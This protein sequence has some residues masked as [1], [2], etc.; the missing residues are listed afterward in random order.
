MKITTKAI[1]SWDNES[2]TYKET[3]CD[4]YL[5]D[6]KI[7]YCQEEN[8][9]GARDAIQDIQTALNSAILKLGLEGYG[10]DEIV[11]QL[12]EHDKRYGL[13]V[14]HL[15]Y[16][17]ES[18]TEEDWNSARD[19]AATANRHLL[20]IA[21]EEEAEEEAEDEAGRLLKRAE[22]V[23]VYLDDMYGITPDAASEVQVGEAESYKLEEEERERL[24]E[25]QAEAKKRDDILEA[26]GIVENSLADE[27][28]DIHIEISNIDDSWTVTGTEDERLFAVID[29]L[30][31]A[32]NYFREEDYERADGLIQNAKIRLEELL[33]LPPEE[34]QGILP[35][36][37]K[38]AIGASERSIHAMKDTTL[39]TDVLWNAI[40]ASENQKDEYKRAR[41]LDAVEIWRYEK[42][43]LNYE[44]DFKDV[45]F[46]V[47]LVGDLE[48]PIILSEPD[49]TKKLQPPPKNIQFTRNKRGETPPFINLSW[50][51]PADNRSAEHNNLKNFVINPCDEIEEIINRI[52]RNELEDIMPAE[53]LFPKSLPEWFSKVSNWADFAKLEQRNQTR[54][55]AQAVYDEDSSLSNSTE[56]FQKLYRDNSKL[57]QILQSIEPKRR[58]MITD[59]FE[60]FLNFLYPPFNKLLEK[61]KKTKFYTDMQKYWGEQYKNV[62]DRVIILPSNFWMKKSVEDTAANFKSKWKHF[63]EWL[64]DYIIINEYDSSTGATLIEWYVSQFENLRS[65]IF[66]RHTALNPRL[67]KVVPKPIESYEQKRT[68]DNNDFPGIKYAVAYTAYK[69][70][71][72]TTEWFARDDYTVYEDKTDIIGYRIYRKTIKSEEEVAPA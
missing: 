69:G 10:N 24:E 22:A 70:E 1:F 63:F 2:Q 67:E 48:N 3:H 5:Y 31:K 19:W 71:N 33:K 12:I 56:R 14:I 62:K 65:E 50:K 44:G 60:L 66:N 8:E 4:S 52:K 34:I 61:P 16:S 40:Q 45:I 54:F 37:K 18:F 7:D 35:A 49:P 28:P 6:G 27:F 51:H 29:F 42:K 17:I 72:E 64:R 25:D 47:Y 21:A 32:K 38:S 57:F 36:V 13:V 53:D 46:K 43:E 55:L 59:A 15:Q 58:K 26:I 39:T 20:E 9:D 68:K 41:I 30:A 11:D 23:K